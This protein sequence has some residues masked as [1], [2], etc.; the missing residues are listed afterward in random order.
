MTV[1][2][3]PGTEIPTQSTNFENLN[4]FEFSVIS[5][6]AFGV[7]ITFQKASLKIVRKVCG[8]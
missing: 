1:V 6:P 2:F 8:T 3:F 5:T 4:G 7:K